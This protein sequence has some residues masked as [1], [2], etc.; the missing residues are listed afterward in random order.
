M[1]RFR[2][3]KPPD[4]DGGLKTWKNAKGETCIGSKCFHVKQEGADVV[5]QYNSSDPAC[6][7]NVRKA[8]DSMFDLI[9]K[10]GVARF[11]HRKED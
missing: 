10:G 7:K 5:V 2:R 4:G 9:A 8:V 3:S 1:A 11:R 6:D